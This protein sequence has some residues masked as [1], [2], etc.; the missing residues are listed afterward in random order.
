MVPI[1]DIRLS[2]ISGVD[3]IF[4]V[5]DTKQNKQKSENNLKLWY[6]STYHC[7]HDA[8]FNKIET[9]KTIIIF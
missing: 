5:H 9:Q 3:F 2:K 4:Y 1:D 6:Y 7:K 8:L